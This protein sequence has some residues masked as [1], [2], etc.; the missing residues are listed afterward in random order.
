MSEEDFM[1]FLWKIPTEQNIS[2]QLIL[3]I[4]QNREIVLFLYLIL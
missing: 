2:K 1:I 4:T 3:L